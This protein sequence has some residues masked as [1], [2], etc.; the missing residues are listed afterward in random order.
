M[1]YVESV[2]DIYKKILRVH[3]IMIIIHVYT[4][5]NTM[6]TIAATMSTNKPN[7]LPYLNHRSLHKVSATPPLPS[8]ASRCPT[9]RPHTSTTRRIGTRPCKTPRKKDVMPCRADISVVLSDLRRREAG[10][11]AGGEEGDGG[12]GLCSSSK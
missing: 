6:T 5:C 2:T 4:I 3:V 8:C 7:D 9:H 10:V 12:F 1:L 11:R